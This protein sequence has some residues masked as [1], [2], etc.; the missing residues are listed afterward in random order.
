[1]N[2]ILRGTIAA[3][4]AAVTFGAAPAKAGFIT[5]T[6]STPGLFDASSDTRTVAFT[7]AEAGFGT[8]VITN[9]VISIN[10]AKAD[11]ES[12]DP[13]FPGGAPFYNEIVF[14]LTS[15][16][17]T[18]VNLINAGSFNVGSGQFDGTITF[19][20]SAAQVV[21]DNPDQPQAGTFRPIGDLNTLNGENALGT[22]SLFIQDTTGADA[23]RF[24]SFTLDVNTVNPVPAP[25]AVVMFGIGLVGLAGFRRLRR[26]IAAA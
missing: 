11:G 24:R 14:R 15:P 9:V 25:P 12:F 16:G 2:R 26:G 19:D 5:A 4:L 20:Q 6:N 17:G 22:W 1:M 23:L 13:P 10:F 7:G 21:N 3:L 18:I 8:G